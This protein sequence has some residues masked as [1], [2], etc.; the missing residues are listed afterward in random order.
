MNVVLKE[1]RYRFA[2]SGT[3]GGLDSFSVKFAPARP[4]DGPGA[5]V[6]FQAVADRYVEILDRFLAE[7]FVKGE[8]RPEMSDAWG[9]LVAGYKY[10]A[11]WRKGRCLW[12]RRDLTARLSEVFEVPDPDMRGCHERHRTHSASVELSVPR[13]SETLGDAAVSVDVDFDHK[14]NACLYRVTQ[15]LPGIDVSD[16]AA[17]EMLMLD[18]ALALDWDRPGRDYYRSFFAVSPEASLAGDDA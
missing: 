6:A 3:D 7:D 15:A 14:V 17:D 18:R 13:V 11:S 8:R 1:F 10:T 5:R 4:E 2:V 16:G 9:K 12:P